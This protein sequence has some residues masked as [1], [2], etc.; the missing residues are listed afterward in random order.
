MRLHLHSAVPLVAGFLMLSSSAAISA[1]P[2]KWSPSC[3]GETWAG[4]YHEDPIELRKKFEK[5]PRKK[6]VEYLFGEITA[7]SHPDFERQLASYLVETEPVQDRET[8]LEIFIQA[9]H[10]DRDT[11]TPIKK[12]DLCATYHRY[13]DK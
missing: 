9:A 7:L 5:I 12:E 1:P 11:A 6:L 2:D 3:E 8:F 4:S 13:Y 10:L